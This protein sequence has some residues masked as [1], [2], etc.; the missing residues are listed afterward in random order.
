[1]QQREA[2]THAVKKHDATSQFVQHRGAAPQVVVQYPAGPSNLQKQ[3]DMQQSQGVSRMQPRQTGPVQ[4]A[5]Q[6]QR[7]VPLTDQRPGAIPSRC[8]QV[9]ANHFEVEMDQRKLVFRYEY[10]MKFSKKFENRPN[11]RYYY[12]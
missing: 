4:Q 7:H 3:P 9:F 1:V 10:S 5:N 11:L 6:Q 2:A 8:I 12:Y